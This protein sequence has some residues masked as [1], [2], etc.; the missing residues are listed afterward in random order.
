MYVFL[1][2]RTPKLS[3]LELTTFF[4]KAHA[5]GEVGALVDEAVE[6]IALIQ[7]LGGTVKIAK[8]LGRPPRVDASSLAPHLEGARVFGISRYDSQKPVSRVLL[9]QLKSLLAGSR[10]VEAKHEPTL[11]SVVVA[12]QNVTEFVIVKKDD[13]LLLGKTIAVQDFESWNKRD[14][15]RPF[16]DPHRGMLPPK[17]ARMIVNSAGRAGVLLDPF[18]GMGTILAEAVLSGWKGIGSDQSQ[19][20]VEKAKKNLEWL[21]FS[22]EFFVCDAT[23]V[24][25]KIPGSTIDAIVTEPFM[26][27]AGTTKIQDTVRGLEK[28]YIGCLKDWYKVLKTHGKVVIALPEYHEGGKTYFVKKVIDRAELLGYTLTAGP[29]EYSRPQAIVKRQF[30]IFQK[31]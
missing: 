13:G 25:E 20:V 17:V 23:H 8:I 30:Y 27:K 3:F 10:F 19:E 28:L 9:S 14:Y 2:G 21:G 29:I 1:F 24:S 16:A 5:V 18:C 26:G 11:S 6:P 15:G 22:G 12:K 31:S 4:P 7:K